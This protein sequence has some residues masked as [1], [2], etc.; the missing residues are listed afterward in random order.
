MLPGLSEEM[1]CLKKVV[2]EAG[3]RRAYIIGSRTTHEFSAGSSSSDVDVLIV[4]P[5]GATLRRCFEIAHQVRAEVGPRFEMHLG[6]R[7]RAP[8][9]LEGF[10][11]YLTLQGYHT[12]FAIELRQ[13][14]LPKESLPRPIF[15]PV[16]LSEYLCLLGESLWTELRFRSA[17][18]FENASY[19]RAKTCLTYLNNVLIGLG[20]FIPTHADRVR[21]WND[22]FGDY[23]IL[24]H[25]L[26]CKTGEL[27]LL[28][29]E[30][31]DAI[32]DLRTRAINLAGKI[33]PRDSMFDATLFWLPAGEGSPDAR[34]RKQSGICA[35][36]GAALGSRTSPS[37]TEAGFD[38]ELYGLFSGP[39]GTLVER[40]H[41]YRLKN[42]DES[43]RDWGSPADWNAIE[44]RPRRAE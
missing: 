2:A 11:R 20:R 24:E 40:L 29:S 36:L 14:S 5:S 43:R 6:V 1:D 33:G 30:V 44:K 12:D 31:D 16:D 15:E 41:H 10:A 38:N 8:D 22:T 35:A 17:S 23:P 9:E 28:S 27:N 34:M 13:G 18:T 3:G 7:C 32:E 19:L 21:Y 42:S 37:R 26:A 4:A 25:A 39:E